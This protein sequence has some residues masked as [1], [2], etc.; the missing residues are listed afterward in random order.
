MLLAAPGLLGALA[1]LLLTREEPLPSVEA[2]DAKTTK[3]AAD[4]GLMRIF[5]ALCVAMTLGG[6][7]YRSTSVVIPAYFELKVGFL[8]PWI[9]RWLGSGAA[10][11]ATAT[12]LTSLVYTVGILGQLIGGRVADRFDLR[13]AY[14]VFHTATIPALMA[15]SYLGGG[16][17]LA[18]SMVY[19]LFSLGMQPIE[20][21]LVAR[22]SPEKRRSTAYGLKFILTFGVGAVAVPAAAAIE[23]SGSLSQV[24]AVVAC[25]EVALVL[26]AVVVWRWSRRQMARLGND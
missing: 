9:S 15:M 12:A 21:S 26:V 16:A 25:V 19:I 3:G 14:I 6:F 23:R 22:L 7:A 18:A 20:N 5:A 17:L 13:V 10:L 24:F 1:V 8:A 2:V 4:T 11:T